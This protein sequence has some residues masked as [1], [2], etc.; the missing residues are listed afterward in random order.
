MKLPPG[1]DLSKVNIEF[2]QDADNCQN[3]DG[4]CQT[5]D[6]EADTGGGGFFVR[7]TTGT[8]G[9]AVDNNADLTTL[10]DQVLAITKANGKQ[11]TK[12]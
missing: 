7:L 2:S 9:W 3:V 10:M 4:E 8:N 11:G 5:L 12:D 6:I 1:V